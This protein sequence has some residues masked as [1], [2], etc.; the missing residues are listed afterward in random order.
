[1]DEGRELPHLH[2]VVRTAQDALAALAP[3]LVCDSDSRSP[4]LHLRLGSKYVTGNAP[5]DRSVLAAIAERALGSHTKDVNEKKDG[6]EIKSKRGRTPSK[7]EIQNVKEENDQDATE[8]P[9]TKRGGRSRRGSASRPP[10]ELVKAPPRSPVLVGVPQYAPQERFQP[11]PTLR[12][13]VSALL[14]DD[15]IR[16]AFDA[17]DQASRAVVK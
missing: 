4:Y 2:R 16:Y 5:S 17:L 13:C 6:K 3:R 11:Q 10:L 14:D 15:S 7:K 12:V 9:S 8:A 1:V